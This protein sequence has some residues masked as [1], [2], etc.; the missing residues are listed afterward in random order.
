MHREQNSDGGRERGGRR[1]ALSEV[2]TP[3][4]PAFPAVRCFSL[5]P[6][7]SGSSTLKNLLISIFSLLYF[8][9]SLSPFSSNNIYIHKYN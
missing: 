9:L 8:Q 7:V 5:H 6:P 2:E 4:C 3:T 1:R